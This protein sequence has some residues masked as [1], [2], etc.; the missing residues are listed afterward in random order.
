MTEQERMAIAAA[1]VGCEEFVEGYICWAYACM[2][3]GEQ[4][5]KNGAR[6][7]VDMAIHWKNAAVAFSK[8]K[9]DD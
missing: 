4:D 5:Y 7:L 8:V 2:A 6:E 1:Q 9:T 3:L